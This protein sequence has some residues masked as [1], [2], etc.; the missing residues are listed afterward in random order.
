MTDLQ[1]QLRPITA[2]EW[3]RFD[4]AMYAT[5]GEV[6][7]GPYL[8]TPPPTAE[9]DRSLALFDEDRVVATSGIYSLQM[10]VPGAVVPT[11]GITWITVAPSHRRRGV[12]RALMRRQLDA[13]HEAQ[14]EPVAALWAAE[15]GIYGRFGYAA[16]TW[17]G[18]WRGDPTRLHLRRDVDTGTGRVRLVEEQAY[19]EAAV[20]LYDRLRRDVPGNLERDDRWWDRRLRDDP[21]DRDGA[22]ARQYVL[23]TETDGTVTG[24]A[25][26]RLKAVWTEGN[27]PDGVLTVEE[28]RAATPA[29]YAA[30]WQYLLGHD[31]VRTVRAPMSSD[32]DPLRHL[33]ADPR[34]LHAQ[35]VDALWVRLV[36]VDRALEARRYPTPIDLVFEVQDDTCAWN[37]GRWRLSGHPAGAVCRATD[38][39]PDLV[40]GIEALSAAYLGGVSLATLQAAGRVREVSPGAVTLASAAFR[41]PVT[42]WCPDM[43]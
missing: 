23:H 32:D 6:P 38:R 39:D 19:R 26:Y 22:T 13:V 4:G 28:V 42:P 3:P 11:A 18:A 9:L 40:I 21:A 1:D 20:P 29:A 8:E 2:E 27:E 31:L 10:T 5:F 16:A 7:S 36:D 14:R 35:P 17:R 34:A 43:F 25:A 12:L 33:L 30:L 37:T 24:Y 41:W 15:A